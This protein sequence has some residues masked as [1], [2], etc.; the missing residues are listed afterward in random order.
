MSKFDKDVAP[1][2]VDKP[3]IS[4]LNLTQIKLVFRF[5]ASLFS[6]CYFS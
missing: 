1:D 6:V 2:E 5:P 3:A 4:V